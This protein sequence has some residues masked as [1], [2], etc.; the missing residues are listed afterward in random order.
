[1]TIEILVRG[2]PEWRQMITYIINE[3]DEWQRVCDEQTDGRT[4]SQYVMTSC[5]CLRAAWR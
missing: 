3:V 2:H 5:R 4:E 1:M